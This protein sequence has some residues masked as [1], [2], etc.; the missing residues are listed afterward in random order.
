MIKTLFFDF[1]NVIG[2]FD[3][4]RALARLAA[5][6]DMAPAELAVVLYG[7]AILDDYE[8]GRIG[9]AEYVRA[10]LSQRAAGLHRRGVPRRLRGHLLAQPRGRRPH[11]PAG[12]A[13][14]AGARQQHQRRP[15]R[16][17]PA[18]V[19]RHARPVRRAGASHDAPGPQAARRRSSPTPSAWPAPNRHECLFIDDLPVNVEAAGR[20]GWQGL[21]YRP[22]GTLAEKLRAAG[23]EIGTNGVRRRA[24]AGRRRHGAPSHEHSPAGRPRGL[25]TPIQGE[26]Q[27]QQYGLEMIASENYTSPA[28]M[29]AQGSVLTNK[30]AEGYPGKRY[31]G[32]CEFVDVAERLAIDRVQAA[33]RRRPRQ[34]PAALRRPG[35]HG[36]VPGRACSRATPSS[37]ST[38]PTA[39]T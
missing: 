39:A 19:R 38:W 14:P 36:R 18:D 30:Y 26:R 28:V 15:L 37:A 29:A 24:A 27:R 21:V 22:D 3:H 25:R 7:G 9:T 33:V 10:G 8:H 6:T 1:G 31:Y 11:P 5:F 4:G 17:L 2:F 16:P 13:L 35:Q 34:R 32:G 23:V 20:F 12:A